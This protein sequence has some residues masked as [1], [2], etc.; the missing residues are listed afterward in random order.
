VPISSGRGARARIS[1]SGVREMAS[2]A[3]A[4]EA[5]SEA[6][7][8]ASASCP[9]VIEGVHKHYTLGDTTIEVLRGVTLRVP[10]GELCAVMGPSGVGKSTLL[11]CISGLAV[12]DRGRIEVLGRDIAGLSDDARTAMRRDHIGIVYQFFN[13]V[14][15]L[16][17]E[18]NVRLP[19]LIA[20]APDE[21]DEV[22]RTLERVGMTGRRLHLPRQ[23]SGGEMQ[24]VSIA[25]ALVRKPAVIL[26]D[27]PTGNVNVETGRKI[28][29]LLAEVTRATRTAMLLVTHHPDHAARADRVL[30]MR[31]G[32]FEAG[33]SLEGTAVSLEAVHDRLK[34]LRI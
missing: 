10:P 32:S 11:S 1:K 21:T 20:D 25:R 4:G 29:E 28:M 3:S 26:A 15:H 7:K 18:E 19:F 16:N 13:L 34:E 2:S 6:S 24:L 5:S 22:A 30:F 17:V 14:P 23:L 27:E 9:L 33:A 8:E 12:P 31:D